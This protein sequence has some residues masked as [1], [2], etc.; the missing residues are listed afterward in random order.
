MSAQET[1]LGATLIGL[2]FG[3]ELGELA[4]VIGGADFLSLK[5]IQLRV[6]SFSKPL[7]IKTANT[8][9]RPLLATLVW[10]NLAHFKNVK[11]T[12]QYQIIVKNALRYIQLPRYLFHI[13]EIFGSKGSQII[14]E[15]IWE[16]VWEM[17]SEIP[18]KLFE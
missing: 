14:K 6:D 4:H 1:E 13:N 9:I 16:K 11:G 8:N 17:Y 7:L 5:Q 12:I 15:G 10:N 3:P 18:E 2:N